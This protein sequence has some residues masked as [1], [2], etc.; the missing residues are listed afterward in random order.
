MHAYTEM[1]E[2]ITNHLK[3]VYELPMKALSF[4]GYL[5]NAYIWE[6]NSNHGLDIQGFNG[7]IIIIPNF[8]TILDMDSLQ[9]N[10]YDEEVIAGVLT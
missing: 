5:V 8:G 9:V 10:Y 3:R 2:C 4:K 6:V 7:D 1:L